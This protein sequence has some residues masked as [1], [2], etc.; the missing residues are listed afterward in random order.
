MC[1]LLLSLIVAQNIGS[2]GHVR[3]LEKRK[4]EKRLL[5][6]TLLYFFGRSETW[7]CYFRDKFKL[8]SLMVYGV[9]TFL[10]RANTV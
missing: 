5:Q 6:G 10:S 8:G 1:Q 4:I 7:L 9:S 2:S 3:G